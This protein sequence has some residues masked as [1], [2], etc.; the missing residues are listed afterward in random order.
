MKKDL[1]HIDTCNIEREIRKLPQKYRNKARATLKLIREEQRQIKE[2]RIAENLTD[3]LKREQ[4]AKDL[5][6]GARTAA[7]KKEFYSN[8]KFLRKAEAIL[9]SE[10]LTWDFKT[11][12]ADKNLGSKIKKMSLMFQPKNASLSQLFSSGANVIKFNRDRVH[13][14]YMM[15]KLMLEIKKGLFFSIQKELQEKIDEKRKEE[16]IENLRREEVRKRLEDRMR[17][18]KRSQDNPALISGKVKGDVSQY[19]FQTKYPDIEGEI[20][21]IGVKMDDFRHKTFQTASE[22]VSFRRTGSFD[23][24]RILGNFEGFG[25]GGGGPKAPTPLNRAYSMMK[26]DNVVKSKLVDNRAKNGGLGENGPLKSNFGGFGEHGLRMGYGFGDRSGV[27]GVS[28]GFYEQ[29]SFFGG[30]RVVRS[31]YGFGGVRPGVDDPSSLNGQ[32]GR[33][34]RAYS[35]DFARFGRSNG[36]KSDTASKDDFEGHGMVQAS[37]EAGSGSGELNDSGLTRFQVYD[38]K[39][40][41]LDSIDYEAFFRG[42][43]YPREPRDAV[44]GVKGLNEEPQDSILGQKMAEIESSK[45]GQ[46]KDSGDTRR[47]SLAPF[48]MI[49]VSELSSELE[50]GHRTDV[51]KKDPYF[52]AEELP[53]LESLTLDTVGLEGSEGAPGLPVG[54]GKGE[55]SKKSQFF[56]QTVSPKKIDSELYKSGLKGFQDGNG[57]KS[58]DI[59]ASKHRSRRRFVRIAKKSKNSKNQKKGSRVDSNAQK[60]RY[61]GSRRERVTTQS[62]NSSN[63]STQGRESV[64]KVSSITKLLHQSELGDLPL[65]LAEKE[66]LM[67]TLGDL[68]TK[69]T[70]N[71]PEFPTI[72]K[73]EIDNFNKNFV[74]TNA[75]KTAGHRFR[76]TGDPR[77]TKKTKFAKNGQ[78]EKET[79]IDPNSTSSV[80]QATG[81]IKKMLKKLT[82]FKLRPIKLKNRRKGSKTSLDSSDSNRPPSLNRARSTVLNNTVGVSGKRWGLKRRTQSQKLKNSTFGQNSKNLPKQHMR[83]ARKLDSLREKINLSIDKT[84]RS[85]KRIAGMKGYINQN[86]KIM[87][88]LEQG[89]GDECLN[90]LM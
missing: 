37:E 86:Y 85:W 61:R 90:E 48:P 50:S 41:A 64:A 11:T 5:E 40:I 10:D 55:K 3:R 76:L 39:S 65:N 74:T 83:A 44:S 59:Q 1:D 33:S 42:N 79:K 31:D 21:Q 82:S 53:R 49:R 32:L 70:K 66:Q 62:H 80:F 43:Y 77:A 29:G 6:E 27:D 72:P 13:S 81:S 8:L 9:Y 71:R 16:E 28:S 67:P 12:Q 60:S 30:G 78:F 52:F 56:G 73:S 18:M 84:G 58:D 2:D 25:R 20:S 88:Y 75:F 69:D 35:S 15:R 38:S 24:F 14:K 26:L 23:Q 89:G 63:P 57:D 51:V 4:L 19:T 68:A 7:A 46:R 87:K 22:K 36:W 34:L 47:D 17:G 54:T 45:I